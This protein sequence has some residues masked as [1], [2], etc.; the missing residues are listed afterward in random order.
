MK[1]GKTQ[2]NHHCQRSKGS[3]LGN[4]LKKEGQ[5]LEKT[6]R[7]VGYD[8]RSIDRRIYRPELVKK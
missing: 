2:G 5:T 8:L 6:G 7:L 1:K 4:K 3:C